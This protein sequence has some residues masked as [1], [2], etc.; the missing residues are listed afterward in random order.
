MK[1]L[2]RKKGDRA[3]G[4]CEWILETEALRAWLN[5]EQAVGL[6][7]GSGN[8]LWLWGNPGTGKSTMTMCLVERLREKFRTT[9]QKTL[10]YF[11]CDFN[12]DARRSATSVV[13]GLILQL[14][15]QHPRLL[16]YLVPKY[17]QRKQDIFDSF[18]ALWDM[19][20]KMAADETT[21]QT[22]FIIDALDECDEESRQT[23]VK[24]LQR[25]FQ[26][27]SSSKIRLLITSRPYQE[28]KEYLQEFSHKDLAS[29]PDSKKDVDRFIH[30]KVADLAAKKQ[31]TTKAKEQITNILKYKSEKTFLW[32]GLACEELSQVLSKH[33][34][35]CLKEM[36]P[37]LNVL[38]QKLLDNALGKSQTSYKVVKEVLGLVAV[39]FRHLSILEL[40]SA[41]QNYPDEDEETRIQFT[42]DDITTCRLL[43]VIQ[44]ERVLLLHQSVKDFVFSD[45]AQQLVQEMD[46][47]AEAAYKCMDQLIHNFALVKDGPSLENTFSSYA[48][49]YWDHHARRAQDKFEVKQSQTVF[50]EVNSP[51]RDA[52]IDGR[53]CG[54]HYRS[55]IRLSP[56]K[57]PR[58]A[59]ALHVT[60]YCGIPAIVDYVCHSHH[61]GTAS[62]FF[63]MLESK[64]Q[65][66]Y[67]PLAAAALKGNEVVLRKLLECGAQMTAGVARKA[68][69]NRENGKEVIMLLLERSKEV[70]ITEVVV[71]I[72]AKYFDEVMTL[73]L[74]RLEEKV[75]ITQTVLRGA[76][77]NS[78]R[79]GEK[80][81]ALLL[82]RRGKEVQITEEV[83]EAAAGNRGNGEK[84]ITLF[85]DRCGEEVQITQKVVETAA[86]NEYNG[87]MVMALLF[88]RRGKEIQITQKVVE[89][90]AGNYGN[91]EKVMAL[92]LNRC[93]KEVQITE[94]VVEAAAGNLFNGENVMALLLNRCGKEV[95]ITEKVVEAAVGNRYSGEKL[96]ALLFNRRGNEVQ[97]TQGVVEAV[98]R[99]D[100]SGE[101]V[102]TLLIDRRREEVERSRSQKRWSWP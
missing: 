1:S 12:F 30:E 3:K 96:M 88:D 53:G 2:Q 60:G 19:L 31:Y 99:N 63:T 65:S 41:C 26:H 55:F 84:M 100:V 48:S 95:Q 66:G 6:N 74:N 89:A 81:M 93:G 54:F 27:E 73:L 33:A 22:F 59:S 68:A 82:D 14:I 16:D 86:G 40:S 44:D 37:G 94:K 85:L 101:K 11:F 52:W 76:A 90:A 78:R 50:F 43:V 10:S 42:R 21:G 24:Q 20:L 64:D 32:V 92:L 102:M 25:N 45:S 5:P 61:Q 35:N 29:I 36:P 67:T 58:G 87:E 83:V 7:K 80:L 38:Y 17:R 39:S 34:V 75:Q 91:G 56:I 23:L 51:S 46:S 13:R 57:I 97:I 77:R 8:I 71:L 72:V 28:I 79:N 9:N 69:K 62:D 47:H 70:Q 98:A 15:Q 18:D 4:T 49:S